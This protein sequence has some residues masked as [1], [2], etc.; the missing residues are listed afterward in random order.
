MAVNVQFTGW[1]R[2]RRL[3]SSDV[4]SDAP[5]QQEAQRR[6]IASDQLAEWTSDPS[7]GLRER[8]LWQ[9]LYDSAA[10]ASEILNLDIEDLDVSNRSAVV[11]GKGGDAQRVYWTSATARPPPQVYGG[12][13]NRAAFSRLSPAAAS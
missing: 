7:V 9:M 8:L 10:R 11:I 1:R 6:V 13:N 3:R 5:G 2:R 12:P 4:G